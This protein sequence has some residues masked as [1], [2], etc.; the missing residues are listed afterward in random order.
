MVIGVAGVV[1]GI[2]FLFL[3]GSSKYYMVPSL[4]FRLFIIPLLLISSY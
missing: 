2:I 4:V 3:E 1:S